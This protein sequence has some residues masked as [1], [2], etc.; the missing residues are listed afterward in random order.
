MTR[1]RDRLPYRWLELML[2]PRLLLLTLCCRISWMT[3]CHD[4]L[5]FCWL[6]LML[7]PRLLLLTFC[8]DIVDDTAP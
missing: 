4:R 1:C 7:T 8:E 6:E 2:T 5:P 3:Q